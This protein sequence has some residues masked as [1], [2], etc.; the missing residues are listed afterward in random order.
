MAEIF[1]GKPLHW[2]MLVVV[3]AI[4][5]VVGE[6]HLHVSAFNTFVWIVLGLSIACLLFVVL[7]HR[8]GDRVMREPLDE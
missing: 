4:L 6:Y 2:L 7:G 8:K 1:L 3:A 5:W